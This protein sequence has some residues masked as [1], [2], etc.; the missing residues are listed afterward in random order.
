MDIDQIYLKIFTIEF[1]YEGKTNVESFFGGQRYFSFQ[2]EEIHL[3][4]FD[5]FKG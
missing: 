1:K 4:T 5:H 2:M 3:N